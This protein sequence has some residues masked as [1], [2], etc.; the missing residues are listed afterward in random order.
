MLTH[1]CTCMQ[2]HGKVSALAYNTTDLAK[3]ALCML[4]DVIISLSLMQAAKLAG[5]GAA[6]KSPWLSRA[7]EEGTFQLVHDCLDTSV[8]VCKFY[9]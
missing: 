4:K 3:Q 6:A 1:I 5:S 9:A 8:K 2:L 7:L